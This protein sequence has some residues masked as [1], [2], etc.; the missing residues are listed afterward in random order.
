MLKSGPSIVQNARLDAMMVAGSDASTRSSGTKIKIPRNSRHGACLLNMMRHRPG[1]RAPP[2]QAARTERP[3]LTRRMKTTLPASRLLLLAVIAAGLAG[4]QSQSAR[5][6]RMARDTAVG[7][8]A[9]A[10]IGGIIGHNSGDE[11][12][13]GAAIGAVVGGAAGAAHANSRDRQR[14]DRRRDDDRPRD[15]DYYRSMLQDHEVDILRARARASGR[16]NYDLTDFLTSE[17][18]ANLRRRD[19]R[20]RGDEE[21]GR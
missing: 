19:A 5:D 12:G 2:P 8:S 17:E 15:D 18:K 4:C 16:R 6:S 21:I 7:A 20:L 3:K 13:T 1:H 11:A 9:G 10:V 14:D